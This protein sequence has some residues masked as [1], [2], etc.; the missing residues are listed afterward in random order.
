MMTVRLQLTPAT[1]AL[2]E[3]EVRGPDAVASMLR[4]TL[5]QEWPPPVFE[6]DDVE[7]VHRQLMAT[8][9][10]REWTLYYVLRRPVAGGEWP[11]LIGIAG[12]VAPPTRDGVVEI[13]YAIAAE[14]QRRGY[15]TEAVAALLARAFAE[16]R[17]RV[18]A[19][20]TYPTLLASIRV[21]Q[22]TGFVEV[23]RDPA[24][25]LVRFECRRSTI[26]H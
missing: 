7:R 13:G 21:L 12:Y 25:N 1:V 24:T 19:A 2:C 26:R 9:S 6:R 5:P 16:A 10:S 11:A 15:A 3:A 22:K 20:T 14:H 4:A 18:V 23:S 17:V 8:P